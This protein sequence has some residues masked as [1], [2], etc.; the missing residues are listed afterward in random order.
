MY[1]HIRKQQYL[2]EKSSEHVVAQ[3]IIDVFETTEQYEIKLNRDICEWNTVEILAFYRK[4]ATPYVQTLIVIHSALS[5]YTEWCLDNGLVRDNQNHFKEI[6]TST[7][8]SCA[9][10]N[11]LSE[12]IFTREELL[13]ELKELPNDSDK[14][15]ILGLFEGIPIRDGVMARITLGDLS[16]NELILRNDAGIRIATRTLSKELISIMENAAA[17]QIYTSMASKQRIYPYDLNEKTVIKTILSRKNALRCTDASL[18]QRM[19]N[20]FRWLGYEGI[21][22]K[23]LMESG[24]IQFIKDLCR[25]NNIT[26]KEAITDRSYRT[27][28]EDIYGKI[29]S[30]PVYMRTYGKL[31]G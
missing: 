21:T 5:Q 10:I 7:V 6:P 15:I 12:R 4:L 22:I 20:C 14:F 9:D 28:H 29:Q 26:V 2:D 1:N 31:Y 11:A 16:G 27:L 3:N 24:R 19:R 23:L 25:E 18:A 13:S 8:I 17:E 30:V